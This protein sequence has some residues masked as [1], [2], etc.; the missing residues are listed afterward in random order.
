[1]ANENWSW[2][3]ARWWRCDLHVHSPASHDFEKDST[4]T[5]A[6]LIAAAKTAAL[7]GGH[8]ENAE[9]TPAVTVTIT[10]TVT[11]AVIDHFS[12]AEAVRALRST[13]EQDEQHPK[14][15]LARQSPQCAEPL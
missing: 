7:P 9:G 2:P 5:A 1:M 15:P 8:P 14:R 6:D 13:H 10:V 12:G 4:D 11:V 3:G